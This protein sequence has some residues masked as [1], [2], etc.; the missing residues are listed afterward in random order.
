MYFWYKIRQ[1][2]HKRGQEICLRSLPEYSAYIWDIFLFFDFS[3]FFEKNRRKRILI[4]K[5]KTQMIKFLKVT[6]G[7]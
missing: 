4:C 6:Q 3:F 5:S 1:T 7:I 2:K